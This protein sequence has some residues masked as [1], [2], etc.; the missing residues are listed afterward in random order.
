MGY[1]CFKSKDQ[2]QKD[3][4]EIAEPGEGPIVSIA[5]TNINNEGENE[6]LSVKDEETERIKQWFQDEVDIMD[7]NE[8]YFQLFL[9]N[10]FD[11]I[12]NIKRIDASDLEAIGIDK[13]GHRKAILYAIDKL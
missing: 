5:Q 3:V 6:G 9:D 10:G 13:L 12:S 8:K 11:K 7:E 2:K 4:V 1:C